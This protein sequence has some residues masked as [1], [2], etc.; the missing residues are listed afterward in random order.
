MDAF[1]SALSEC[2][3]SDLGY[4]GRWYTWEKCRMSNNN[5]RGR[6]DKAV[7]NTVWW[8]NFPNY[9]VKHLTHAISD[10]CPVLID[11]CATIDSCKH[12]VSFRFDANWILE[13]DI[14]EVVC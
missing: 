4:V 12:D 11:T 2:G 1:R 13:D 8:E 9:S 7:A 3:L 10:H 14:E 6:L 5:V